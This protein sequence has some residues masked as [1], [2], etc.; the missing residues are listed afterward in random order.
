[1]WRIFIFG[2]LKIKN[3]KGSLQALHGGPIT[4]LFK[5]FITKSFPIFC[6]QIPGSE[7]GSGFN[8]KPRSGFN[9]KWNPDPDSTK[10]PDP[11][12]ESMKNETENTAQED[13]P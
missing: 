3:K 13:V 4:N 9:E 10:S 7:S 2:G 12:P 1:L 8:K 11:D 6:H 5:F